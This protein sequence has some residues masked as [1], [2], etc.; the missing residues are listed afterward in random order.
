MPAKDVFHQ[1]VRHALEKDGWTILLT[2]LFCYAM[3]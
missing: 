2:I 3:S 1:A